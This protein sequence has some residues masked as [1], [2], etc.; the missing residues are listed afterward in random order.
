MAIQ[1]T[2][3]PTTRWDVTEYLDSD[4]RIAGYLDA[5]FEDGDPALIKA[6]IADVA[7]AKGMTEVAQKSGISRAGLYKALSENGNPSF[8]TM[9]AIMKAIGVRIA[10]AA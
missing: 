5:V 7:R 4:E 8:E 9:A 6:A 3:W 1:T 10:V 2:R